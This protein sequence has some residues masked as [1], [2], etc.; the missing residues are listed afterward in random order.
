MALTLSRL[1][2]HLS[3]LCHVINLTIFQGIVDNYRKAVDNPATLGAAAGAGRED[4]APNRYAKCNSL[5]VITFVL[6]FTLFTMSSLIN[7]AVVFFFFTVS[8]T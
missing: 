4:P 2:S 1:V 5:A 6:L 7:I 8:T 3:E